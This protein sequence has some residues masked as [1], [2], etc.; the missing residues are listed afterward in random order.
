[1]ESS[2]AAQILASALREDKLVALVG[3]GASAKSRD[4]KREYRGLPT[5][6]QFVNSARARYPYIPDEATF[7]EACDA[8]LLRQR[9]AGLE[10]ALLGVYRVPPKF[11][12]PPAQK[13]LSWL[14][15]SAYIT[16][17]FDQFIERSLSREMRHHHVVIENEDVSRL[18]RGQ[19]P[20]IKY[21]GCVS[22]PNS[23]VAATI[24]YQKLDA[25]RGLVRQLIS[26]SLAS[27]V[28]L[29]I[30]HGLGDSDLSHLMNELLSHLADYAPMIVVLREPDHDSQ[31]EGFELEHEVVGEDLTQFL[32]RVLHEYRQQGEARRAP[33]FDEVWLASA[34]FAKL[35]H[36][37]VL[38]SETQVIDAFLEHLADELGARGEVLTVVADA[39]TSVQRA[40]DQRPNYTA[41]RR[42]WAAL[43][44]QLSSA[45]D[46]GDAERVVNSLIRSREA[47]RELFENL[48]RAVVESDD[49][50]LLYSQSQRVLQVLQGAPKA[51]QRRVDVFVSECRPKSP[52]AYQ[53]AIAICRS[54]EDTEYSVTICPDVVA[55]NL[56]AT[57]QITRVV[58]GT[59]SL[60]R[61]GPGSQPYAFVN[62]CGSLAVAI[63]AERYGVPLVV[64]G[65]ALK[66][67]DIAEVDANDHLTVHQ[68][69]DLLEGLMGVTELTTQREIVGH[70]NIGYDLVPVGPTTSIRV[71]D[72]VES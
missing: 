37:F 43:Y 16:S 28:L 55:I 53:D 24:D 65:E 61:E 29:V 31:I 1:M 54:L 58:M 40:L 57:G 3:S 8:I 59:H 39:G 13:I 46:I 35:R 22:K 15:F 20:V 50:I 30:G 17:N 66:I 60:Y 5:P 69:N 9:R 25:K 26:V 45:G 14:P 11:E 51:I 18:R 7:N 21:H 41:L 62:T 34:F 6:D 70:T 67:E 71:P 44:E 63:A 64:I 10:E 48:S 47:K 12:P 4:E 32:N 38:P 19:T 68:E 56:I 27:R 42:T 33:F 52:S 36:S 23:M 72:A 2:T 49:R